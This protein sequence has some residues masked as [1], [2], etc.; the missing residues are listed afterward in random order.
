MG[1]VPVL[2]SIKSE[3]YRIFCTLSLFNRK[4]KGTERQF[5]QNVLFLC[6]CSIKDLLGVFYYQ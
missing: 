4:N 6:V 3:E 2:G 1:K 5:G